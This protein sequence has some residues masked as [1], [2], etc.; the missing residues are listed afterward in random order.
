[1]HRVLVIGPS[2]AGKSTLAKRLGARL[3]LPL[4]HLDMLYWAAGWKPMPDAEWRVLVTQLA[5]RERW[6]MDGNYGGTLDLRLPACDTVVFLDVP[7][8]L[9]LAR[10][11]WRRIRYFR[12]TRPD[13]AQGNR[14]R[15]TWE[16]VVWIWTYRRRRR[17]HV[18]RR[19][20]ELPP[21]RRVFVLR[22]RREVD[23]FVSSL[24]APTA[25]R[26]DAELGAETLRA[27]SGQ[28]GSTKQ[29]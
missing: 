9:C 20:A 18:L 26:A 6:I 7:R 1:M 10:V 3:G 4:I 16:F 22:S 25:R 8:W 14:E 24:D 17:P 11:F 13:M 21:D 12:A 29:G 15:V 19:L 27:S 2:G 5:A 28:D 23:A